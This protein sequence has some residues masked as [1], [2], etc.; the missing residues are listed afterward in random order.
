V[1][2]YNQTYAISLIQ[3]CTRLEDMFYTGQMLTCSVHHVDTQSHS[4]QLSID[5][6][7]VNGSKLLDL[8][9]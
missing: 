2:Y 4:I 5:P 7:V 6:E 9:S 1:Q 3:H 8:F